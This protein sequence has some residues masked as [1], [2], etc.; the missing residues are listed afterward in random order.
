[1]PKTHYVIFAAKNKKI[2]D[3]QPLEINKLEINKSDSEKYLGLILDS[4][5]TWKLH[6][7]KI[8]SKLTSLNGALRRIVRN[9]PLN[10]RHTIYNSL[11][12]THI[13]YL[14]EIWGAAAKSNLKILQTAQN[15]LIKT[16]FNYDYLTPSVQLYKNVKLMNIDN[17]F[18]YFTCI[19]I[20]K[21]LTN[22]IRTGIT[23]KTKAQHTQLKRLRNAN[24]IILRSPRTNYGKNNIYFQSAQIYNKLPNNIKEAKTLNTFKNLLKIHLLGKN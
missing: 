10:V 21:I 3:F 22:D 24:N 7:S 5:L 9:L 11:V 12:K 14:I 20:R 6:I 4:G 18:K 2:S 8:R 13:D 1:M 16:L 17:T 15:K 23:F 19:L